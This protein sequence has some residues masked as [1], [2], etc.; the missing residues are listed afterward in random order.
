MEYFG[1]NMMSKRQDLLKKDENKFYLLSSSPDTRPIYDDLDEDKSKDH[2]IETAKYVERLCADLVV[3]STRADMAFL[4]Y[5]LDM[6]RIEASDR[7]EN[8][9]LQ[10]GS[11]VG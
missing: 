3:L 11:S 8:P 5:L 4:A 9:E 7:I 1:E 6:A 10:K 2:Q